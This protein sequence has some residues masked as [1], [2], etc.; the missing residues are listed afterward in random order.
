MEIGNIFF[1]SCSR[2]SVYSITLWRLMKKGLSIILL[3]IY[4]TVS[5]GFTV[6]LHYCMDEIQSWELGTIDDEKCD[7]CGM[8]TQDSGCCRDEERV[9][10]LQQDVFKTPAIAYNFSLPILI[11]HTT[12]YLL[13]PFQNV[14]TADQYLSHSPPLI[15]KQDTYLENC[16]FR[17]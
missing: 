16:V 5:T 13:L 12:S 14:K 9:L 17:I 3:L 7:L 1:Q 2:F 15:N 6:N 10:K 11:S 4:F 8:D